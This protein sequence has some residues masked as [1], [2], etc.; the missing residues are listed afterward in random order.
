MSAPSL[1]FTQLVCPDSDHFEEVLA[2]VRWMEETPELILNMGLFDP[3]KAETDRG[4][5]EELM[6]HEMCDV[7]RA[8]PHVKAAYLS[9]NEA[10]LFLTVVFGDGK[11]THVPIVTAD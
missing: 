11:S 5:C 2:A 1:P 6:V 3:N 10:E 9:A 4:L 8:L 7:I